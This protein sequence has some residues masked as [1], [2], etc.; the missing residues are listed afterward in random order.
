MYTVA[1]L[2]EYIVKAIRVRDEAQTEFA[3]GVNRFADR[4]QDDI[5]NLQVKVWTLEQDLKAL[6]EH[7]R[8]LERQS[9]D[10]D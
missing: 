3:Q 1:L 5:E 7:V 2:F 8:H 6:R 9:A 10:T 4:C